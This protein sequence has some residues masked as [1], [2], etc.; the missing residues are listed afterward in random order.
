MTPSS[1]AELADVIRSA[2]APLWIEGGH[3]R[4]LSG[5]GD[6]ISTKMLR[7]VVLYEPEA[8]T[9]VVGAGTP[10]AEVEALLAKEGQR[11][12]F[13]PSDPRVLT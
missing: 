1:D 5:A 10:V 4:G 9:L 13:E 12:A 7:G 2:T 8:L 6:V 3:T 11:L